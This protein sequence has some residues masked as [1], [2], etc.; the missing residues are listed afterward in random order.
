MQLKELY[1][2]FLEFLEE[3]YVKESPNWTGVEENVRIS[4]LEKSFTYQKTTFLQFCIILRDLFYYNKFLFKKD[5]NTDIW[6]SKILLKFLLKK[7]IAVVKES[8]VF[9]KDFSDVFFPRKTEKEIKKTLK[10]F[11]KRKELTFI[12][13]LI[14]REKF[15]WKRKYDQIPVSLSSSIFIASK[16]FDYF[17]IKENLLLIGDDDFTSILLSLLE[18]EMK[19]TVVDIDSEV[20]ETI[21]EIKKEFGLNNISVEKRDVRYSKI[22]TKNFFGFLTNPPYTLSGVK[23][24]FNFGNQAMKEG[25]AFLIV[26]NESIK[27][28]FL[29]L[30]KFFSSKN[31][32]IKEITNGKVSFPFR[33]IFS[34]DQLDKKELEEMGIKIDDYIFASLYV[35]EKVPWKIKE[36]KERDIYEYL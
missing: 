25:V 34:E 20:L 22:K 29:L 9:L 13:S 24:F 27:H 6:V 10:K 30:Q 1:D 4:T 26:G 2:E 18:P 11:L 36:I 19:I 28:R 12:E 8:K 16:I 5:P 21:D 31:F 23:T 15:E 32:I 17:P 33:R 7:E 3:N 35:L 14:G